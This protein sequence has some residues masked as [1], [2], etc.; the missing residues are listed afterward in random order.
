MRG[1]PTHVGLIEVNF[2]PVELLTHSLL[3][4]NPVGWMYFRPFGAVSSICRS[5]IVPRVPK[6]L[7]GLLYVVAEAV[8]LGAL[9]PGAMLDTCDKGVERKVGR[10]FLGIRKQGLNMTQKRK[11]DDSRSSAPTLWRAGKRGWGYFFPV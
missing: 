5:D 7:I 8:T 4:N 9:N 1:G 6:Y 2:C 10:M 3:M 11:Q